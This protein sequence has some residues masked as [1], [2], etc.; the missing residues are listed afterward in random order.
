MRQGVPHARIVLVPSPKN[1]GTIVCEGRLEAALAVSFELDPTVAAYRGQPFFMPGPK[2]RNVVC[3]FAIRDSRAFYQVVDVKPSGM[4]SS[5]DVTRRMRHVRDLLAESLVPHR[6]VT[7][8]ELERQPARQIR[9]QLWKGVGIQLTEY[10]RDQLLAFVRRGSVT[11]GDARVFCRLARLPAYAIEKLAIR[12]LLAF[13]I[14]APWSSKTLI[15]DR[16]EIHH[17]ARAGWGS[18]QDVVVRL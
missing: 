8:I 2:N 7:E 1:G 12:N 16:H 9:E 3:D 18:V 6:I 11:V 13:E 17:P 4:L 5:P 10:Q 14:A 15:G